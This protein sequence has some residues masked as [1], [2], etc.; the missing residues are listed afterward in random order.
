MLRLFCFGAIVMLAPSY[1]YSRTDVDNKNT[2]FLFH[3]KLMVTNKHGN[4]HIRIN[5]Y[6]TNCM[7]PHSK[8]SAST[9]LL[10]APV[11]SLFIY[12]NGDDK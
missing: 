1:Y 6:G 11:S 5:L 7:I 4:S 2:T 12:C 10:C 9:D 3:V 8:S